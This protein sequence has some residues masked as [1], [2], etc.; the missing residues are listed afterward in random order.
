MKKELSFTETDKGFQARLKSNGLNFTAGFFVLFFILTIVFTIY[1][2]VKIY[3]TP[4]L[5]VEGNNIFLASMMLVGFISIVALVIVINLVGQSQEI[6]YT[7]NQLTVIKKNPLWFKTRKTISRSEIERI[8][9]EKLI[10]SVKNIWYAFLFH[11]HTAFHEDAEKYLVP[12][13]FNSEHSLAFFEFA[14]DYNKD[15][16]VEQIRK[17]L[18]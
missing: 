6:I 10:F 9:R 15:F 1:A 2:V 3:P 4:D 13:V 5:S 12:H 14:E 11:D 7:D 16:I 18:D 17:R 8:K